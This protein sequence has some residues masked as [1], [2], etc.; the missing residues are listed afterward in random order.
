MFSLNLLNK[1]FTYINN[2]IPYFKLQI[3]FQ[4]IYKA[5]LSHCSYTF[6][7]YLDNVFILKEC[8]KIKLFVPLYDFKNLHAIAV[9]SID[10]FF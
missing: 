4:I 1:T 9:F 6:H 8:L 2:Q 3:L 7:H 5:V 10:F